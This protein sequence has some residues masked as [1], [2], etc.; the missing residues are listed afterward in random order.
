[1]TESDRRTF[2]KQSATAVAALAVT[3]CLPGEAGRALDDSTLHAVAEAVLPSELGPDRTSRVV[4][5]FGRW[6]SEFEPEAELD[7]GYIS[8]EITYAPPDPTPLWAD[9]L[10]ALERAAQGEHGAPFSE[11]EVS[12]RQAILRQR[13]AGEQPA[14]LGPAIQADHVAVAV[15][16][17]FYATPEAVDV[18]YRAGIGERTCRPLDA[19]TE[20]PA[21][22][23]GV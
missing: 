3:R 12:A 22:E 8:S 17:F 20:A 10:G 19:A 4:A 6:L 21:P 15:M 9:Q 16:A 13:I 23:Q 1:M 5:E 18:C 11:L 2:L 14:T 7:H